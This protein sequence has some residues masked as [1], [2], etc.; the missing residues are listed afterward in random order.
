MYAQSLRSHIKRLLALALLIATGLATAVPTL[1]SGHVYAQAQGRFYPQTGKTLAPEFISF[2]DGKGGVPIFG[3]PLTEPETEGGVKVQYLERARIEF[4]PQNRNTPY[5]VQLGL[6][7]TIL[8]AGRQ[9]PTVAQADAPANPNSQYFPETRHT[10]AGPFL[11]Y[12]R[13]HGGLALFG[14]PISEPL[15]EGGLTVQYFERNRFELHPDLAGTPYEVQLGLLGRDLLAQRVQV[16]ETTISI[17]T[18]AYEQ[19]FYSPANDPISPYPRLDFDRVGPPSPRNYRLIVLENRYIKLTVLPQVGGRLYEAIYKPTGHNELYRNPVIKPGHFGERGWWLAAGGTEWA[20]PTQEHGLME[21][22]PW[23][24]TTQRN[25][26]GG[27]TVTLSANDRLTGLTVVS[28]VSLSPEEAAYTLS[29][30]L[31]NRTNKQAIGQL[32]SNAILAPGGTN[33]VSPRTRFI[34][35]ASSLVVHSTNDSSLP[36]EHGIVEWPNHDG[37]DLADMSTWN[38]WLGA[39]AMPTAD[40]G[41]FAAVYNPDADE[42]LVKTFKNKEMP[43]LKIFGFGRSL[44]P[45]NYTDDNS[46]YAE[47]WGGIVPTFWDNALFPPGSALGWTERWQPVAKTGGVSL[48]NAWGTVSLDG[49]T[50]R[51]LPTRRIEGATVTLRAADGTTTRTPFSASPDRPTTLPAPNPLTEIEI[52]APD[53]TTLLKG[54]P[55]K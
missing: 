26:D 33:T 4:H 51:I 12:W 21:Y 7:G 43:G 28:T 16:K 19:A 36:P 31:E 9:F 2:Y 13:D 14:F 44:N 25:S 3:Y 55:V 47:L 5:E 54:A 1:P 27:A 32:W 50:L 53:G 18:Y 17:P 23:D 6:L 39:F 52:T 42:G 37:K 41:T 45:A 11:A 30:R 40:R 22:L 35:P 46:S 15:Q 38:G 10:L 48:A 29:S 49:N 20:A 24:A 8:T 34:V